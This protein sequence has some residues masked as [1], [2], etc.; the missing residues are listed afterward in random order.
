M[1][2]LLPDIVSSDVS[3]VPVIFPCEFVFKFL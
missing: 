1:L 3:R 2:N